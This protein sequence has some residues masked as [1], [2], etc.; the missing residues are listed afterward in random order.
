M[1][2]HMRRF[3]YGMGIIASVFI[4]HFEPGWWVVI[5]LFGGFYIVWGVEGFLKHN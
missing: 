5:L 3:N 2:D 1:N 4:V